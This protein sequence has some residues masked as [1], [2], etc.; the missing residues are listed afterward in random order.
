ML[1]ALRFESG[2]RLLPGNR[3]QQL[4]EDLHRPLSY[5]GSASSCGDGAGGLEESVSVGRRPLR[6]LYTS[7]YV[8]RS[9]TLEFVG[10]RPF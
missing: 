4:Q 8:A 1:Q 3:R 5:R 6:T 2:R 10:F 9:E 7:L